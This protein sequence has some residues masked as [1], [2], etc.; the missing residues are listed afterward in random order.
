MTIGIFFVPNIALGALDLVTF[1]TN[2]QT[3]GPNQPVTVSIQS[4]AIDLNSSRITWYVDKEAVADGVAEKS[5]RTETKG[6]GKTVTINVV[7]VDAGGARFDK[8]FLLHPIEI[9]LLW[10]ADTYTPPFYKGKALPTYKSVVKATAI[11]RMYSTADDPALFFYEWTI[12]RIQGVGKGLGKG[13]ALIPMKYAGSPVPTTVKVSDPNVEGS[14]RSVTQNILAVEPTVLFYEQ[15]PLLGTVFD[16]ALTGTANTEGTTFRVRATPYFFSNDNM[17]NGEL[18]YTWQKDGATVAVGLNPNSLEL[19]KAGTATQSSKVGLT[20][21]NRSR[22]LQKAG[23]QV[24]INFS[25]E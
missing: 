9:D 12:N 11:P 6:F 1:S 21:Q 4:Y 23:G 5:I 10:E 15:A 8:E 14:A 2:P 3:P 7:I 16:R 22:I 18:V 13:G 19:G 25:Q 24:T 20:I 17:A